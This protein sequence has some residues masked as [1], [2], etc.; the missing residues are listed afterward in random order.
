LGLLYKKKNNVK[1]AYFS[2]HSI[3]CPVPQVVHII[4]VSAIFVKKFSRKIWKFSQKCEMQMHAV[5]ML[6]F[7]RFFNFSEILI[8]RENIRKTK[9]REISRNLAHFAHAFRIFAK[10][11]NCI[12]VSTLIKMFVTTTMLIFSY[13]VQILLS[14]YMKSAEKPWHYYI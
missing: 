5:L 11:E 8:F 10:K 13:I 2:K 14:L 4:N 12:F 7:G 3:L 9:F 1:N 6:N